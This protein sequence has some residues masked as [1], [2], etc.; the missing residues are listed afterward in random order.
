VKRKLLLFAGL[1]V[2]L[3]AAIYLIFMLFDLAEGTPRDYEGRALR[4][5]I[6]VGNMSSACMVFSTKF[7]EKQKKI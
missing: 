1:S 5:V 3:I 2:A 7:F 4:F 6:L